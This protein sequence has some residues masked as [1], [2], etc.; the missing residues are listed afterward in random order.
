M[1]F[2]S[3]LNPVGTP[4]TFSDPG[5]WRG[6]WG[7]ALETETGMG[8]FVSWTFSSNTKVWACPSACLP[9]CLAACLYIGPLLTLCFGPI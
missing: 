4:I 3:D 6:I 5:A 7:A 8:Y 2:D 1:Q 9:V